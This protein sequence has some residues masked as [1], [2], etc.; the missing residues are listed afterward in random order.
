MSDFSPPNGLQPTRFLLPWDFPGKS[1]GVGCHCL[2][3]YNMD[4][5][6]NSS[7][8]LYLIFQQF[9]FIDRN[10][11]CKF[12]KGNNVHL[13]FFYLSLWLISFLFMVVIIF[14]WCK[15]EYVLLF[16]LAVTFKLTWSFS[17]F[18]SLTGIRTS[19]AH[20]S[21]GAC[22][23]ACD[24]LCCYLSLPLL[25]S[26]TYPLLMLWVPWKQGFSKRPFN[27]FSVLL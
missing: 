10:I 23:G 21:T 9:G 12:R 4:L 2:L 22:G 3:H 20:I 13:E 19:E 17:L 5:C 24:T 15:F 16:F 25:C 27:P 1:T 18:L 11:V 26:M 14:P 8:C 6:I 7:D